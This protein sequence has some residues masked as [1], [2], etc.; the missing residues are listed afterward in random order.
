MTSGRALFDSAIAT[1]TLHDVAPVVVAATQRLG[2]SRTPSYRCVT[3]RKGW[4]AS[5][6]LREEKLGR[7]EGGEIGHEVMRRAPGQLANR[8]SENGWTARPRLQ[9]GFAASTERPA[10][11]NT[12]SVLDNASANHLR[13]CYDLGA[14]DGPRSTLQ[15]LFMT[16]KCNWGFSQAAMSQRFA[17]SFCQSALGLRDRVGGNLQP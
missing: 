5:S 4:F 16:Q 1:T 3:G 6:A 13:Q 7:I 8:R 10:R 14:Q 17:V 9:P 15:R 11:P 12:I 2:N